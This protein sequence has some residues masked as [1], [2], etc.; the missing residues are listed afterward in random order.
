MDHA[1]AG[2]L[3]W[4]HWEPQ[5]AERQ[6]YCRLA[7]EAINLGKDALACMQMVGSVSCEAPGR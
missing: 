7:G 4:Q 1:L 2:T 5:Q 3:S 6:P